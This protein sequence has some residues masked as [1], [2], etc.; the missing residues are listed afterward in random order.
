MKKKVGIIIS[1]SISSGIECL[2]T[3]KDLFGIGLG[4]YCKVE[5]ADKK[6]ICL[7]TDIIISSQANL[8]QINM[9]K[10]LSPRFS[11]LVQK[12]F[13]QITIKLLPVIGINKISLSLQPPTITP[14]L[15]QVLEIEKE[16]FS[17]IFGQE[18]LEGANP[19]L[20]F[21]SPKGIDSQI[22][23]DLKKIIERSNGIFGKT[24]TGKTFLARILISGLIK[25]KICSNLIFDMHGEYSFSARSEG[26]EN[27]VLGLKNLL[28]NDVLLFSLDPESS[29]RRGCSPDVEV[30]FDLSDISVED[31]ITLQDELNLHSTA[32][33][34]ANLLF[35][36]FGN[37]W[38]YKLLSADKSLKEL[39][40]E[41]GAH[42]ESLSALY[43]KVKRIEALSFISKNGNSKSYVAECLIEFLEKKKNV[44]LE[45]GR[46]SSNLAYLLVS[47]ILT[48]Q[49]HK[50]FVKK[51]ENFLATQRP[52]DKPTPLVIT[53]E[54][55]HNFLSPQLAK[56]T[57]FGKIAR[58]MRKYFVTL[59][60]VDQ[61]PS[62]ICE[63]ILSQLGTRF[64]TKLEDERDCTAVFSGT[65][66]N[67]ELKNLNQ[68]LNSKGESIIFGHA[69]PIPVLIENRRYNEDFYNVI[70]NKVEQKNLESQI[71]EIY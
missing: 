5:L 63:E 69:T 35:V 51:T 71:D 10:N 30:F 31:I 20:S 2:V 47:G 60:I 36:S 49:I 16:D 18:I 44:I 48:R 13:S 54:E 45:F 55:A 56:Q 46:Q 14:A 61:R 3:N 68:T 22:C 53:I 57:I 37:K 64:L 52:E 70:K 67:A 33:E 39:A 27:F 21:G 38:L 59:L 15:S 8:S 28:S 26:T 29:R 34:V 1:G 62:G 42:T 12:H 7:T 19:K 65:A 17:T 9:E 50:H 6:L 32:I 11:E 66:N 25:S 43:R 24:G 40:A 4:N 58:E 41:I 23:L